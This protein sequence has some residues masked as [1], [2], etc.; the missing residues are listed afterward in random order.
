LKKVLV[1]DNYDSFTYNL[2]QLAQEIVAQSIDVVRNDQ[3]SLESVKDYQ[4][5]MLSPGPGI[6]EEAGLLLPIIRTY[7]ATHSIF[8]VCLGHQ[9]IGEVFGATLVNLPV[10]YHG[11]ATKIVRVESVEYSPYQNDWYRGL[12][13]ELWVGRY[14][15]WAIQNNAFPAQLTITAVDEAGAIM[16]IRH[17]HFDVQGVQFHPESILTPQGKKMLEN[18]LLSDPN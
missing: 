11:V 12:D 18:W 14:H 7:A 5:I 10:V 4:K 8:G 3:L 1:I 13:K 16:A 17:Q 15:S 6:P 2:V 9:A